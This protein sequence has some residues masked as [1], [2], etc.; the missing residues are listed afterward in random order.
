M[1]RQTF[2]ILFAVSIILL[3]GVVMIGLWQNQHAEW[4]NYQQRYFERTG[5][6]LDIRI[7]EIVPTMTGQAELCLTCHIGLAE[8]SA[9]HSIEIFGCVSCHGGNGTALQAEEAHQGLRGG[10]NPSDLTVAQETCGRGCHNGLANDDQNHVDRVMRSLQ[11]TY[12]G[13]I[14]EVRFAFGAQSDEM[15][16]YGVY[17]VTDA[18]SKTGLTQ[19]AAFPHTSTHSI[20][21]Q[22]AENCLEAGCHLAEEAQAKPY[23]YRSTGC[24]ACHVI[25]ENDGLYQGNDP[26]I[27]RDEPGRMRLHQ[28]TTAIP[29]YQCNHCHNR[30]NYSLR[31]MEFL[32]RDDIPPDGPPISELMPPEGRRLI[33]YYQP[34]GQFTW[35][36]WELDCIECHTAE[37]SMGDGDIYPNQIEMQYTQC[38]TCH[39]TLEKLPDTVTVTKEH[40]TALRQAR[41]N[42]HYDLQ[43]GEQVIITTRGEL[44]GHVKQVEDRL[45]LT[46][47]VTGKTYSVNP[48]MESDCQQ[49]VEEQESRYCHECHAHER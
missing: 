31:Q 21:G 34:I 9:S 42:P 38:Q 45:I 35:C 32:L 22:F 40:Q 11:G 17:K 10:K 2:G 19:L 5:Q 30:G 47:K 33:E 8:I 48:V 25:Y 14:A 20:D 46:G 28:F 18:S 37:E 12:A 24:A 43:L 6:P 44:M 49:N 27:P 26:T 7:R 16:I 3:A 4:Q 36:E 15:P 41:L 1:N 13:G 23:F 29:F 39:G